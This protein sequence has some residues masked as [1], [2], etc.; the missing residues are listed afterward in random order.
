M[1]QYGNPPQDP[2]GQQPQQPQQPGQPQ[3]PPY[4]QQP[5]YGQQ[6]PGYGQAP[7]G[8]QPGYGQQPYGQPGQPYGQAPAYG[9]PYGQQP[10]FG[11]QGAYA[12]WGQRVIG[13]LW[14][15]LIMW[16]AILL[17]IVGY[18][19]F[20]AAI[21]TSETDAYGNTTDTNGGLLAIGGLLLLASFIV[22]LVIWIRNYILR[23]GRTGYSYGK[24][25]VGIRLIGQQDGQPVGPGMAFVRYLLHSV[26]NQACYIDYLWPLWDEKNQTLTDKVLNTVVIQQPEQ[27]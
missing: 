5:G 23:Q 10:G 3:Q 26:I 21:A 15:F 8:Q 13:T 1:S 20:I 12:T 6:Q 19:L 22:G 9:A 27:R 18:G 25:K 7:Y 24:A 4:G 16:P 2:Y 14:D 17:G 11:G